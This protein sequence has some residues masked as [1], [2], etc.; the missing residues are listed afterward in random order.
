MDAGD[1]TVGNLFGNIHVHAIPLF[2]R[3]YVWDEK[4]NWPT[5][6]NDV[7]AATEEVA[8]EEDSGSRAS[9]AD[10]QQHFLGAVVFEQLPKQVRRVLRF[11]I[12]DG[13]QRLTTIQVLLA[14]LRAIAQEFEKE[15]VAA[16][17]SGLIEH[18]TDRIETSEDR[19]KIWPL[20]LDRRAFLAAVSQPLSIDPDDL[21]DH[22]L[23]KARLWFESRIREQLSE[24]ANPG[25]WIENAETAITDRLALVQINLGAKDHPQVI[26]EALN[27]RG[28]RL[29]KADLVKNRVFQALQEQVDAG[30]AER[31]LQEHWMILDSEHFRS[32][33]TTGR[34][35]R[36]RVDLLMAYWLQS[37]IF[38]EVNVDTLFNQFN[39][40][41]ESNSR[42]AVTVIKELHQFAKA[43][44]ELDSAPIDSFVG[45]LVRTMKIT[46][47]TTPWP[48]LLALKARNDVLE[49]EQEVVAAAIESFLMRRGIMGL[50]T[51][52]YNRF[53]LSI[54]EVVTQS[55]PHTVGRAV[56]RIL[57]DQTADTRYWPSD[58]EFEK[59]LI[60]N[61]LYLTAQRPRLKALLVI[62]EN[63]LRHNEM[64]VGG[65]SLDPTDKRLNI[66][67][68]LPQSWQ[69]HWGLQPSA[70][71]EAASRRD[72]S[73]HRLG[74]L[75]LVTR[76]LNPSLSN[77]PWSEKRN[78]L[79]EYSL[80]RL[81]TS[82]VLSAPPEV[83][84]SDEVWSQA[85]DEDRI[86]ARGRYLAHKALRTWPRPQSDGSSQQETDA[87]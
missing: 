68:I 33:V 3:P 62:L 52:D 42:P 36:A 6:W 41:F 71:D 44:D 69:E 18:P 53:F 32:N 30:E 8:R 76:K 16:R 11:N 34:I 9:I 83:E 25:V 27:H 31:L 5:L 57:C 60:S 48:V 84:M 66:E 51:S 61:E 75:T 55:E 20:P 35:K 58:A 85:W 81:T 14:A 46:I 72:N 73:V 87:E 29:A 17:L 7:L 47:Q 39:H 23:V 15:K 67:H 10:R 45:R 1:I 74:N 28:V 64:S 24:V 4:E 40:W 12:I 78:K 82:S 50:E 65:N 13:Q 63:V 38:G 56:Q 86:E 59:A 19:H 21:R 70:G 80:L 54:V 22:R 37:K 43:F 26:F 79:Q 77:R 49:S 2:Q